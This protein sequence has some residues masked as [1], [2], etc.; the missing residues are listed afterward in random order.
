MKRF[1]L[2]AALLLSACRPVA[3]PAPEPTLLFLQVQFTPALAVLRPQFQACALAQPGLAVI[4]LERPAA[5]LTPAQ[6][7]FALRWDEP[8]QIEGYAAGIAQEAL[9]PIVHPSNPLAALRRA[10]IDALLAGPAPTWDG[11][12]PQ[13]KDRPLRLWIYPGGDDARGVLENALLQ[14]SLASGAAAI[15]PDPQAMRQA[16]AAD[17]D[18][19]GFL[20]TRWLDASVRLVPLDIPSPRPILALSTAEPQGAARQWLLCLQNALSQE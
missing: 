15:A 8:P 2:C 7:D 19:L 1:F 4:A 20:P 13:G 6:V 5:A 12:L 18:A 9:V 17:P 10:Q 11:L 3:A 16:I 14:H